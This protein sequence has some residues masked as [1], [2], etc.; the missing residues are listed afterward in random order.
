MNVIIWLMIA[1]A[2]NGSPA[3]L[4]RF[5]EKQDCDAFRSQV[6]QLSHDKTGMIT[7]RG[8]CVPAKTLNP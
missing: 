2:G 7:V 1:T 3:V 6:E 4:G 8:I 5:G